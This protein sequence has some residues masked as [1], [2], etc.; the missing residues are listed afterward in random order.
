MADARP[1]VL[2]IMTDQQRF[3]TI[4][5]LGNADIHTPHLDRLVARGIAFRNAYSS[6]PVCVP[7][8]Y[9][10][11]TGCEMPRL[12]WWG[13]GRRSLVE[14][15]PEEM[16]ERCGPFLARRMGQLGYRT[17]GIGKFHSVHDDLGYEVFLRAE[18][19]WGSFEGRRKDAYA[20]FIMDEHPEFAHIEQLHGERTEMY[21]MPQ[22]NPLPPALNHEGWAAREAVRLVAEDNGRPFFG[23]VSFIGPHPP[24]APP[25]PFNRMYDPDRMPKPV[26]GSIETDHMDEQIP[27]MNHLIWG[28]DVSDSRWQANRA[29]Y[30]GEITYIDQCIGRILDTV[31]ARPD[32][33]N[34]LIVFFTDHGEMLGDHHAVQKESYF[35][36]ACHIP[37]LLSWPA[38]LPA[39]GTNDE[40]VSLTDLFGIATA[41]AGTPEPRDGIDVLAMLAGAARPREFY[42]GYYEEPGTDLFKAMV[43][44]R[45]WKYIFCANGGREQLFDLRADPNELENLADRRAEV[46][47]E[48]RTL[49][50]SALSVPNADRALADGAL[51]RFPYRERPRERIHQ[52]DRSHGVTGFP[53]DPADL[54]ADVTLW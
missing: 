47:D 46:T 39:G 34:T 25:V 40:L 35:E 2:Y 11:R 54:L 33:D 16:E 13:N 22:A 28:D 42:V 5:A 52:F 50:V 19:M 53:E 44:C 29:R 48:L 1:N 31:D 20:R 7:A 41:A 38:R 24:L 37:F 27:W 45:E 4:A 18:E 3:D 17:F 8:R 30:Y 26:R 10:I 14:G 15:Q 21:Y 49:L 6:C 9:N 51:K 43:R 23:F 32:A 12:G 36:Q